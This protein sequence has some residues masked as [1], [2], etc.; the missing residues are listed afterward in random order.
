MPVMMQKCMM[1]RYP[2]LVN[3]C[4]FTCMFPMILAQGT[5]YL[6]IFVSRFLFKQGS[7]LSIKTVFLRGPVQIDD[8]KYRGN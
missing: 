5:A 1:Y 6:F 8:Y 4:S 3:L 2:N 7:S